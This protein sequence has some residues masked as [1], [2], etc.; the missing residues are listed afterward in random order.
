MKKKNKKTEKDMPVTP[1]V[2]ISEMDKELLKIKEETE[3]KKIV[4]AEAKKTLEEYKKLRAELEL[5]E[6]QIKNKLNPPKLEEIEEEDPQEN[7]ETLEQPDMKE[8]RFNQLLEQF[9]QSNEGFVEIYRLKENGLRTKVGRYPIKDVGSDLDFVARKFG[10]GDYLIVLKDNK[11]RFQGQV[12]ESYDE[13]A[14]PKPTT[15]QGSGNPVIVNTQASDNLAQ[16]VQMMEKSFQQQLEA[17]RV[18]TAQLLEITKASVSSSPIK[19]LKDLVEMKSLLQ[20]K[21][22]NP[23]KNIETLMGLFTKGMEFGSSISQSNEGDDSFLGL[24]KDLI[25]MVLAQKKASNVEEAKKYI[26]SAIKPIP[27]TNHL[28]NPPTQLIEQKQSPVPSENIIEN[29]KEGNMKLTPT[30]NLILNLYKGEIIRL[31]QIKHKPDEVADMILLKLPQDYYGIALDIAKNSDR[32]NLVCEYIPELKDHKEWV[33]AVLESG[34]NILI[35]YYKSLDEE[36]KVEENKE[37]KE[38]NKNQIKKEK[39]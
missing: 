11:G 18:M 4:I 14:Y 15:N 39:K 20:E 12:S 16:I 7:P 22:N 33:E 23:L 26:Q 2:P 8:E 36:L 19:S 5:E 30:G 34:K 10:G 21:D 29:P 1:E 25:P 17:Q 24:I 13:L 35:D 31:A 28:S 9:N 6:Q 37:N 32:F 38:T 3:K 27:E